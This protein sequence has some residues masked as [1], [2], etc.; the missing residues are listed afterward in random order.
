M[1]SKQIGWSTESNLLWE[2][3][4]QLTKLGGTLSSLIAKVV[5]LEPKY[6]VYTALLTQSGG[7]DPQFDI[8]TDNGNLVIGTTYEIANYDIEDDFTNIGAPSNAN[9]VKFVATGTTA[10]SW[11]GS[12]EL[13]YNTGA[14]I[15]TVL[16]NTI[17]NIWF[18]YGTDGVYSVYS[19]GLFSTVDKCAVIFPS[20]MNRD[21]DSIFVGTRQRYQDSTFIILENYNIEVG[22]INRSNGNLINNFFEIR[23]YS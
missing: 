19:N 4:R 5:N 18:S 7:D 13:N 11:S 22:G 17:G 16:E 10:A 1:I 6:K 21:V 14:P 12:S 3:L 2:I 20:M 9:G 15:V 8:N 23:I